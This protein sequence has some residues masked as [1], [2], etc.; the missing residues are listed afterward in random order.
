VPLATREE[1]SKR[2]G[3]DEIFGLR[4]PHKGVSVKH[5]I[6]KGIIG[7]LRAVPIQIIM[8]QVCKLI[9]QIKHLVAS[10]YIHGDIR[11]TNIL[12]DPGTG[13]FT[14]IDFDWFDPKATFFSE[15]FGNFGFYSNPPET[16]LAPH[17]VIMKGTY[18]KQF[19]T[20]F[21]DHPMIR[22][23]ERHN[24]DNGAY[25]RSVS[26]S[27]IMNKNPKMWNKTLDTFDSFGL[28]WTLLTLF[29]HLYPGSLDN[30]IAALKA[31]LATK[32]GSAELDAHTIN[33]MVQTVL[34]P[35]GNFNLKD[36]Q[37]A[38]DV[39]EKALAVRGDV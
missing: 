19:T 31:A 12:V 35:M 7:S 26:G 4:M 33:A 36:R 22:D 39:L 25:L 34:L 5:L 23:I 38:T 10:G 20:F 15:Y 8:D 29:R 13:I 3:R 14:I 6:E 32:Y 24:H 21:V 30:N 18:I 28:A 17:G 16:L 9:H 2:V 37:T 27:F 1:L 11:D